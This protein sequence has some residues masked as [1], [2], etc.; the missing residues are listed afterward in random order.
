[1]RLLFFTKIGTISLSIPSLISIKLSYTVYDEVI[2][3]RRYRQFF[4]IRRA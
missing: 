3:F 4:N 1:M 2:F